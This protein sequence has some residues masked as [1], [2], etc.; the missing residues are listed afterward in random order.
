MKIDRNL[1]YDEFT[2]VAALDQTNQKLAQRLF[3]ENP[4]LDQSTVSRL[5]DAQFMKRIVN[6]DS[7]EPLQLS[8]HTTMALL[9]HKLN[10]IIAEHSSKNE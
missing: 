6:K 1:Q 7:K 8:K 5:L 9:R 3:D 2:V 4:D 10:A